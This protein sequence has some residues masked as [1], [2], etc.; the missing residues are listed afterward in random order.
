[1]LSCD[2]FAHPS[3]LLSCPALR[4]AILAA[5]PRCVATAAVVGLTL[6][7]LQ[8]TLHAHVGAGGVAAAQTGRQLRCQ[9]YSKLLHQVTYLALESNRKLLQEVQCVLPVILKFADSHVTQLLLQELL[10]LQ[11]W[12]PNSAELRQ[13][14]LCQL[15]PLH[16]Q[17]LPSCCSSAALTRQL[18]SCKPV[19]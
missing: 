13:Q 7:Q 1:M 11:V 4:Q 18:H 2:P 15:Y 3:V 5:E 17:L 9:R 14:Q 10:L 8:L 16:Q 19:V 6:R 12:W